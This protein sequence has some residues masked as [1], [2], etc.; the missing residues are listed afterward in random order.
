MPFFRHRCITRK[1]GADHPLAGKRVYVPAMAEGSVEAVC[2]AMRW[3][4]IDARPTPPSDARTL[5]LGSKYTGGDGCFP[6]KVTTGDF[7]KIAQQPG[8]D[9]KRTVFLMGTTDGPCRSGQYA[10]FLRKVLRELGYGE[11]RVYSPHGEH[12]YS[13]FQ[14]FD[15]AFV[16]TAWR[17]LVSADILRKLLLQTRPYE[18]E[19]GDA[20]R[21][22]RESVSDLCKT[23]EQSCSSTPCQMR[24]L[25]ASLLRTR[26]RFHSVRAVF[27]RTRP[28]IGIVGEIYCRLNNFSNQ[29]LVRRLEA[30]GAECWMTLSPRVARIAQTSQLRAN[31]SHSPCPRSRCMGFILRFCS[32]KNGARGPTTRPRTVGWF[33][34][35]A[36]DLAGAENVQFA[37]LRS[38]SRLGRVARE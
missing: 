12:G 15:T 2:A 3:L 37:I 34:F 18:M 31:I 11:V 21:A 38:H 7:L 20:D 24:S 13:D 6:A 32:C 30:Q 9:Q 4:G 10:P 1:V 25:E 8:F 36:S 17:A 29:E 16:R 14:G 35:Q 5:E 22:Y 27:D 19:P 33:R 28:L 23:I 26:D